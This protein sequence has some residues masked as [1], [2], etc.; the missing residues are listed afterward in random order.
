MHLS[1]C[2][3]ITSVFR[4][5]ACSKIFWREF[6]C[7]S[8]LTSETNPQMNCYTQFEAYFS[9]LHLWDRKAALRHM[10]PSNCKKWRRHPW[11]CLTW[12]NGVKCFFTKQNYNAPFKLPAQ[13]HNVNP[14]EAV[15]CFQ[16]VDH[17]PKCS[18]VG[19]HCTVLSDKIW[20]YMVLHWPSQLLFVSQWEL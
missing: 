6:F 1:K 13:W 12:E 5:Y 17:R 15:L 2:S 3:A 16:S 19:P 20:V 7:C 8:Y 11:V 18:I 10:V 9:S 14:H 4:R